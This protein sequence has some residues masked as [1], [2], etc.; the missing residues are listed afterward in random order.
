MSDIVQDPNEDKEMKKLAEEDL[1][2]LQERLEELQHEIEEEI[3]PKKQFDSKNVT[4]EIRQAAGGSESSLFAEDLVN[5]YKNYCQIKGW[6]CQQEEY[7]VD[8]TIQKG[9]KHALFKITGEDVYK[10]LKHEAGVHK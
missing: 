9:C 1:A 8:M 5:M 10:H 3:I 2:N 4:L 7:A 6:R